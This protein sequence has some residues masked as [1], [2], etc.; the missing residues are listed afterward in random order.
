VVGHV[1][2]IDPGPGDFITLSGATRLAAGD[3]GFA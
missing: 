3:F 2:I 1:S